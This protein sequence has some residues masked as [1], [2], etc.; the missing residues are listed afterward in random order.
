VAPASLVFGGQSLRTTSSALTV[1]L[2]NTGDAGLTIKAIAISGNFARSSNC[3]ATLAAGASCMITVTFTPAAA[4]LRTGTLTITSSGSGSPQRVSLS[5][6]GAV[7]KVSLS[8]TKLTFGS[9]VLNTASAAQTVTLSNTGDA[10]LTIRS[11]SVSGNFA[12]TPNCNATVAAGAS[13][14]VSVIFTPTGAGSRTGTLRFTDS[15]AGS[16]HKVTLTGSGVTP[17]RLTAKPAKVSFGSLTL[18]GSSSQ[19]VSMSNTGGVSVTIS[20]ASTS[21]PGFAIG[22]LTTPL[23]LV[24]N[25]SSSFT[26]SFSPSS[27]GSASGSIYLTNDGAS[28]PVT[29]GLSGTGTAPVHEVDLSWTAS[30]TS[31]V[32]GYNVYRSSQPGGAYARIAYRVAGT[33]YLDMNVVGGDTY[34]YAITAIDGSGAES[35]FSD[36]IEAVIPTS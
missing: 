9:Q 24:P 32:V 27:T 13:C 29:I 1:T 20:A 34:F 3:A 25:Q 4:G 31:G 26:V 16:P 28:S 18:D 21:G 22:G 36:E 10:S 11:I 33:M 2:S 17:G 5:G 7:P 12:Q 23:T 19:T 35:G 14:S 6:T 8:D 15:A 30:T